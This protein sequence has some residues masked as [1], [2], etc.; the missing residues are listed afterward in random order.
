[1]AKHTIRHSM[2][3]RASPHDVYEALM[4]S[5]KHSGFTGGEAVISRKVGGKFTTFGG[6]AEGKFI[7]LVQ[8][9]RIIQTWRANDW[10][11]EDVSTI[12]ITLKPTEAGAALEFVQ[13]G[14][15]EKFVEEISQG[16]HDFYWKPLK[17]MLER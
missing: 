11:K 14:V 7:E 2:E 10:M 3:I 15:P 16:W 1:M 9:R 8:D 12:T 4:D 5:E 17:K 6:Y 13:T